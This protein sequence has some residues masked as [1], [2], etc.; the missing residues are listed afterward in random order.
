MG[1]N[2][3]FAPYHGSTSARATQYEAPVFTDALGNP[4]DI[5]SMTVDD[6]L[7]GVQGFK[8]R[9]RLYLTHPDSGET[10][11][12]AV[13]EVRTVAPPDGMIQSEAVITF[14]DDTTIGSNYG[15]MTPVAAGTFDQLHILDGSTYTVAT[16]PPATTQYVPITER[17]AGV[18]ALFTST[19]TPTAFVAMALLDP[20]AT[21]ARG[22]DAQEDTTETALRLELRSNG[23]VKLYPQ[24]RVIGSV[25]PAGTVWRV[26]AQWRY[27]QAT[28][29]G[30]YA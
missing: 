2:R 13:D 12:A 4:L 15:T 11:W 25:V 16:T 19:S 21:L 29:P 1:G 7:T 14:L 24:A 27:G 23:L 30:Q 17:H 5:D 6:V 20:D 10:R 28:N 3:Q 22:G 26:G 8:V 18:S 9:Q